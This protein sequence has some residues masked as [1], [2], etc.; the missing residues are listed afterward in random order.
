[1]HLRYRAL[2]EDGSL[3]PALLRPLLLLSLGGS[4]GNFKQSVPKHN[5]N[6]GDAYDENE[7]LCDLN[8]AR[9]LIRQRAAS[10]ISASSWFAVEMDFCVLPL[11]CS[12]VFF[13]D[14]SR[15]KRSSDALDTNGGR[16]RFQLIRREPPTPVD[17]PGRDD[18]STERR[19][20]LAREALHW[21]GR[22]KAARADQP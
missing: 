18:L 7:V 5:W 9:L 15:P 8:H 13:D 10:T 21:F 12:E 19:D 14:F 6:R 11:V 20:G 1:M 4:T 3:A 17:L 16:E 2:S 22:T